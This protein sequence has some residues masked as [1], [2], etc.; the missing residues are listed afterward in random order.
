MCYVKM[1]TLVAET[2]S[3][4]ARPV[5]FVSS[6]RQG[7]LNA[8]F[9][10]LHIG[11][12]VLHHVGAWSQKVKFTG[13]R[14]KCNVEGSVRSFSKPPD[15]K[16]GGQIYTTDNGGNLRNWEEKT[17]GSAGDKQSRCFN[18]AQADWTL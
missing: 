2:A 1:R 5:R 4:R 7:D 12:L 3:E 15:R 13:S 18:F 8:A 17:S 9:L 11:T 16:G 6:N 10:G 14:D